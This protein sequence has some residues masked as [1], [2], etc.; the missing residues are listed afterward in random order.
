[1][2]IRPVKKE[3]AEELLHLIMN[4]ENQSEFMLMAP[5]ERQM[6]LEKQTTMIEKVEK[7]E[8]AVILI[9]EKEGVMIGYLFAL[10]GSAQRKKHSAYLVAGILKEYR[11]QGAGTLLFQA[12]EE[13]AVIHGISR[14]ELT[15]V[16]RN[17][18][19]IALYKKC[20]FQV[21]GTKRNS[22]IIN[23]DYHDEYYMSKLL[24]R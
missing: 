21:E 2:N 10:G 17:T 15:A 14:L 11:G 12:V 7:Q 23:G 13:W 4:V 24:I 9:A 1:M 22:L 6:T 8:N 16:T 19:G 3:E 5:G 20:G 18:P